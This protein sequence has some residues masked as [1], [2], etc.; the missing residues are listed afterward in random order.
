MNWRWIAVT[1]LLAAL[2]IGYGA[3]TGR[4][5]A[6][7][8]A[9]ST[10]IQPGYYLKDAVVTRTQKDGTLALRLIAEGVVQHTDDDS[11]DMNGVRANYFRAPQSEWLLSAQRARVPPESPIVFL[12]GDVELKPA[13]AEQ[14]SY[15]RTEA[16]AVDTERNVAYTTRSPVTIKFGPHDMH[17]KSF[18]ADLKSEKIRAHTVDGRFQAPPNQPETP[19]PRQN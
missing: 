8:A 12:E 18:E 10:P 7:V 13:N 19:G 1:A 11:I 9:T 6:R 17:V 4:D 15:L 5:R 3:L 16:L 2:V 14:Q